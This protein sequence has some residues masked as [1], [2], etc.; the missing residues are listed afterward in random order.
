MYDYIILGAGV[1]GLSA[2]NKLV[3]SGITNVIALEKENECGGLC[4]TLYIDGHICDI[5]GHF[6]Q[7][8]YKEVEDFIFSFFPK[9]KFY[10]ISP[11]ISKIHIHDVD[12]D[13]PLEANVWQL[14]INLQVEYLTSIIRNGEANG[15]PA[16]KNYEDWIRWKLGDKVCDEYLIPYNSK[17]WGVE[18]DKLDVD[19]LYKIPRIEVDEIL[20]NSLTHTQDITK[21][22]AHIAPYYPL[23]GGYGKVMEA[24]TEPVQNF[25]KTNTTIKSVRYDEET[26]TWVVNDSFSA[27]NIITTI[28]WPDLYIALGEPVEIREEMQK[29]KFNKI[30]IS[31]FE[32]QENKLNYHWRYQPDFKI[33]HHREFFISNFAKNSKP[34]GVFTETNSERFD[35]Q[36]LSFPGKNIYNYETS[37]AYP[38]PLIGKTQAIDSILSRYK[39]KRLYGIGRWGEHKHHN[40]D[41]CIKN[42][43]EL[44]EE[45]IHMNH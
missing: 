18:S 39:A 10:K 8:K 27:K 41:V 32:L 31:L 35:P 28:P 24:L 23:S 13:Y 44:V 34:Y 21:F 17:L 14:P 30:V 38:L 15:C 37:A 16:P 1:T 19:W 7:T 22:P 33:Q 2:L 45:L 43:L 4:R 25:I 20:R 42:A 6:F 5:G 40:Q 36:T 29:I 12:I 26:S 11:R 3:Q 9:D